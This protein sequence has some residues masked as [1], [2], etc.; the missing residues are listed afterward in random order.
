MDF[1]LN[2]EQQG[3]VATAHA[4]A[5]DRL[6]PY[7]AEWDANSHFAKDAL[8]QA[9]R[10]PSFWLISTGHAL[11]LLTV[12]SMLAHLIPYLTFDLDY[13]PVNAGF[14]FALMTA[15][16]MGGLFLGGIIG[17]RFDKPTI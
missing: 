2:E 5:Q 13:S 6:A 17:D 12:S 11:S 3:F 9:V 14:V 16:Q 1:A 7:A 10:E 15:V 4:F 8:R